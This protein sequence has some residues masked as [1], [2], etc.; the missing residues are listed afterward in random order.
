MSPSLPAV[1]AAASLN[2]VSGLLGIPSGF[3]NIIDFNSSAT[4]LPSLTGPDKVGV[5]HFTVEH[6]LGFQRFPLPECTNATASLPLFRERYGEDGVSF[7]NETCS[8]VRRIPVSVFYPTCEILQEPESKTAP[9]FTQS[10]LETIT[11]QVFGD[12]NSMHNMESQAFP[13]ASICPDKYSLIILSPPVGGQRQSYT[14]LASDI[15]SHHHVVVTVDHAFQSG[16][17]ELENGKFLFNLAGELVKP[18]EANKGRVVDLM[19]VA[20]HFNESSNFDPLLWTS[21][22]QIDLLN[23]YVYGHGQGGL[24]ARMLVASNLL[25]GGGTL[26]NLIRMPAPY[27]ESNIMYKPRHKDGRATKPGPQPQ[28][29]SQPMP[30]PSDGD[31][32]GDRLG[33]IADEVGSSLGERFKNMGRALKKTLMDSLSSLICRVKRDSPSVPYGHE[34][35]RD[36]EHDSCDNLCFAHCKLE[37]KPSVPHG[38]FPDDV[39]QSNG[40]TRP[41]DGD[42]SGKWQEYH[43]SIGD[44]E[45]FPG[46]DPH[47][48]HEKSCYDDDYCNYKCCSEDHHDEDDHDWEDEHDSHTHHHENHEYD[49]DQQEGD[50]SP[51]SS[52]NGAFIMPDHDDGVDL[53]HRK[54]MHLPDPDSEDRSRDEEDDSDDDEDGSDDD[55]DD[56]YEDD[57]Q[58]SEDNESE[59]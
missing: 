51:S 5:H 11:A 25:P 6:D 16:V 40:K 23:T 18:R 4:R 32:I 17:I 38:L 3:I 30:V 35:E 57:S 26:D 8:G 33:D 37:C 59:L 29:T 42:W 15:A 41:D 14:Q 19:A 53:P 50:D 34:D 2:G 12:T 27:N 7:I 10:L 20:L 22:T 46:R 58:G 39:G 43:D 54:H 28:P 49:W 52:A 44:Y 9:V 31:N 21:D 13:D 56:A 47:R 48:Q 1:G 45:G 24:V 55:E 36:R